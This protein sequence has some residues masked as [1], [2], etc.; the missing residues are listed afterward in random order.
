MNLPQ[1][2][3]KLK[4]F[5]N[6]YKFTI[7]FTLLAI[8][9]LQICHNSQMSK[10]NF[11]NSIT[12]SEQT[13]TTNQL[14]DS[15]TDYHAEPNSP[16]WVPILLPFL[17]FALFATAL[18]ML[19]KRQINPLDFLDIFRSVSTKGR[20]WQDLQGRVIF[21]LT[22]KNKKRNQSIE[23]EQPILEFLSLKERRK[24]KMPLPDFPITLTGNTSH[25]VNISLQ[26]ILGAHPELMQ[27][28]ALRMTIR[29][30]A[31]KIYKTAPQL[32]LWK[33]NK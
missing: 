10:H 7:I 18:Y 21:T 13:E 23:F 12:Q 15:V 8:V 9:I 19:K 24:F 5:I 30:N 1:I 29:S 11:D 32:V 20:I 22:V 25:S 6:Q 16:N 4:N 14:T 27:F 2:I 31:G 17:I 3:L 33:Q 28:K 26:R